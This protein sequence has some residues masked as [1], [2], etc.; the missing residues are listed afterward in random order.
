MAIAACEA[1]HSGDGAVSYSRSQRYYDA[2]QNHP[3]LGFRNILRDV[4]VL[5]RGGMI[6]HFRQVPGGRGW[7]S[8]FRATD[9]LVEVITGLLDG[10]VLPL[11]L[12]RATI[13]LR[14]PSGLPLRVPE[15]RDTRQMSR[16]VHEIN[17]GLT[18]LDVRC[19]GG[20][21]LSAS[22]VR[23]FNNSME[24]GGRFYALGTNWQN[25]K[26]DLRRQ[27][28]LGG[29]GVVELDFSTL[30][31]SIL[32]AEIGATRPDDCYAIDGWP[33]PLVKRAVCILI[34]APTL[35][36]ARLA[37]A[38]CDEME[39]PGA[40]EQNLKEIAS[41][42]IDDIKRVHAP[43]SRFFHSD[44]GARLMRLDSEIAE[45]VM[46]LLHRKNIIALPVH[47]S[48]LVAK[49]HARDLEAAMYEAAAEKGLITLNV[50]AS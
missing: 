16:R 11:H 46:L 7:Q 24:R 50:K 15:N 29:E 31:P 33:R 12:P 49:S 3:L 22:V 13:Q 37:I 6:D 20:P 9:Q 27:M 17:E 5:E 2:R 10:V 30:H 8:A 4:A 21:N 25:I 32:Y 40:G 42:L 44:A 23:I 36:S 39:L 41:R 18:T 45:R 28:T 38:H 19:E 43:I 34:N 14:D 35:H 47:D 48:F 26:G 1:I